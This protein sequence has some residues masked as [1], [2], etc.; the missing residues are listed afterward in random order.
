MGTRLAG[1]SKRELCNANFHQPGRGREMTAELCGPAE[2]P[3]Y[4]D[5]LRWGLLKGTNREFLCLWACVYVL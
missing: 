2:D 4:A 5:G 3:G 1:E